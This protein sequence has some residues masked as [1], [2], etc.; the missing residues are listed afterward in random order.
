[1]IPVPFKNIDPSDECLKVTRQLREAGFRVKDDLRDNYSPGWK[2]SHWE[3]KGVPLRIEI[4]PRD[5]EKKQV[6][7]RMLLLLFYQ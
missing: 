6:I 4:G 2:Y 5:I 7:I 3:L 1:V